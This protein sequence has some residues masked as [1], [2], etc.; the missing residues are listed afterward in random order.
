MVFSWTSIW[1]KVVRAF[2]TRSKK[3]RAIEMFFLLVSRWTM[4]F[5]HSRSTVCSLWR[6]PSASKFVR[7]RSWSA[8]R[9]SRRTF[10][11]TCC[12]KTKRIHF[13][14]FFQLRHLLETVL[15]LWLCIRQILSKGQKLPFFA[16][17]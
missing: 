16:T 7:R 4:K 15:P 6:T 2:S 12:K 5:S 10:S 11:W 14:D 8:L 13:Q 17:L 9:T 1:S 3:D